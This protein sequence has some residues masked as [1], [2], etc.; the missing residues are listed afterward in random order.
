MLRGHDGYIHS[1]AFSP[2]GDRIVSASLDGTARIWHTT[3]YRERFPAIAAG[4][5]A[6][7]AMRE[8][9]LARLRGGETPK[10]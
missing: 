7:R 2:S 8:P 1:V 9:T 5:D 10:R 4:R 6:D 3:R